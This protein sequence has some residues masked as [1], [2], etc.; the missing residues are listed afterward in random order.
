MSVII[1][2][3]APLLSVLLLLVLPGGCLGLLFSKNK[4]LSLADM[5]FCGWVWVVSVALFLVFFIQDTQLLIRY[6]WGITGFFSC[7]SL[8]YLVLT[9]RG[10]V[11]VR[12]RNVWKKPDVCCFPISL[13]V[14]VLTVAMIITHSYGYDDFSHLSLLADSLSGDIFQDYRNF[15]DPMHG[16]FQEK[17]MIAR[18]PYWGVLI[19]YLGGGIT[20]GVIGAYY[21]L[22]V[23]LLTATLLK[24]YEFCYVRSGGRLSAVNITAMS[25]MLL[26]IAGPDNYFNFGIY[27][28]QQG[29]L[30]LLV[31]LL[32][33]LCQRPSGRNKLF[34]FVGA[35]LLSVS[36]LHHLNLV[37][38]YAF[39]APLCLIILFYQVKSIRERVRLLIF[40]AVFPVI[41]TLM[42][43]SGKGFVRIENVE[44]IVHQQVVQVSTAEKVEHGDTVPLKKRSIIENSNETTKLFQLLIMPYRW[45]KVGKYVSIYFQR[46]FSIELFLICLLIFIAPF[47]LKFKKMHLLVCFSSLILV[48]GTS[49][50]V[51]PRQVIAS[52]YK[53]GSLWMCWDL[54]DFKKNME[55]KSTLMAE[56][57]TAL[58]LRLLYGL[59]VEVLSVWSQLRVFYPFYETETADD[60]I[61]I[62]ANK[63]RGGFVFNQRYWGR[64]IDNQEQLNYHR[65]INHNLKLWLVEGQNSLIPSVLRGVAD[66]L[67]FRPMEGVVIHDAP[68][69]LAYDIS[70]QSNESH[71]VVRVYRD[72]TLVHLKGIAENEELRFS[73]EYIGNGIELVG[74][75]FAE[76]RY[77]D[78]FSASVL[79]ID[80]SSAREP[81]KVDKIALSNLDKYVEF[82]GVGVGVGDG[83]NKNHVEIVFRAKHNLK[84]LQLIFHVTGYGNYQ[85]NGEM[86]EVSYTRG[87]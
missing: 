11:I 8:V 75:S 58:Y 57:Y 67:F 81:A 40:F 70:Y 18:Y 14:V 51:W 32:Y 20:G 45:F 65:Q 87:K 63:V 77:V 46:V 15:V 76:H 42:I 3:F 69:N 39:V 37:L 9:N 21:W 86:K 53:P 78:S 27:P 84:N 72:A 4:A 23:L 43:I 41:V 79:R 54:R 62:D 34:L 25:A 38:L 2:I 61:C 74:F 83:K 48:V 17:W 36:W 73:F 82:V 28:L 10:Q 7:G 19:C 64:S 13:F 24:I 33:L 31:G 55:N 5:F 71:E 60:F 50:A 22:G 29:K 47:V 26:A 68:V 66:L 49:A 35:S 12:L 30:L 16:W 52:F 56:P 80:N 1:A 85:Q 59:E 44:K 6:L